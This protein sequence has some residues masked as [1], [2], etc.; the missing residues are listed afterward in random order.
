MH[1][2]IIKNP[3]TL[4]YAQHLSAVVIPFIIA[5][6]VGQDGTFNSITFEVLFK[7]LMFN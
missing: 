1:L 6:H 3:Y 5:K 4:L 2:F 7:N